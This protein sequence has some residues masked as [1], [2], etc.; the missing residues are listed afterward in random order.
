MPSVTRYG[1]PALTGKQAISNAERK[2]FAL[3]IKLGGLGIPILP[4]AASRELYSIAVT[5]PLVRSILKQ[6]E[7]SGFETEAQQK[8]AQR[9]VKD[10]N[11]HR[12]EEDMKETLDLLTSSTH[13]AVILAQQKGASVWLIEHCLLKSMD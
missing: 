6:S 9:Y 5:E 10:P 3:P 13:T 4:D 11:K 1:I 8:Q 12:N 2:L 7:E